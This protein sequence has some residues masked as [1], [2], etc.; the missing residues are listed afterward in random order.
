VQKW[1]SACF[2]SRRLLN[3]P[4]WHLKH[5]ELW[6]RASCVLCLLWNITWQKNTK[7]IALAQRTPSAQQSQHRNAHMQMSKE[8]QWLHAFPPLNRCQQWNKIA[9]NEIQ[10]CQMRVRGCESAARDAYDKRADERENGVHI[11]VRETGWSARGSVNFNIEASRPKWQT[12]RVALC[13]YSRSDDMQ[14][15]PFTTH[16]LITATNRP[17]SIASE[18][19]CAIQN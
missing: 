7:L 16:S 8:K 6:S 9:I 18:R 10:R 14:S 13:T 2:R 11:G 3:H 17:P 5:H 4:L 12:A 15:N 1:L 19:Q